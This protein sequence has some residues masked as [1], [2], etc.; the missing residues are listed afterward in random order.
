[1][2]PRTDIIKK[3][4][5]KPSKLLREAKLIAEAVDLNKEEYSK[6]S[7]D[8]LIKRSNFLSNK[9][10]NKEISVEEVVVDAFS[11]FREA[12][13]KVTGL[14]AHNVQLMG[15]YI[16]F[17]GNFA[18]MFTGEGKTLT[19]LFAAYLNALAKKSV[20]VVSVN[21]YLVKRDAEFAE[22]IFKH[23]GITVGYNTSELQPNVKREM[24]SR[25]ITY[26]TNSEL[27]FDYLRD[28][29]VAS[30][31]DK[32][33]KSLDFAIIDEGDSVLI[34]E[35]RT[36]LIISGMPKDD[37]SLYKEVDKFV[38]T[39][40]EEDYII[41]L[42]TNAISLS[43][44]GSEKAEKYF[45]VKNLYSINSSDL[46]HKIGNSLTAN[47]IFKSGREYIVRDDAI[48]LVDAFTGRILEGHSYNAGLQQAIQAKEN[49]KI[50]PENQILATITYQSLFRMYKKLS[51]VSGTAFTE[52]EEFL[53]IYN[54]IVVKVPT[55]KPIQRIDEPDYIFTNKEAK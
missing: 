1:M 35:A 6:L 10:Q 52:A 46:Y 51:A 42:E 33:I 5:N 27:G 50:D 24:F 17:G 18:E 55:N 45:N 16:I 34:D 30:Y 29:M 8:D 4:K 36:P 26:T 23:F 13:Y 2:E 11:I 15:A 54:M 14:F 41:D 47:F 22:S 19:I 48:L 49:V 3:I 39:L 43:P 12:V 40:N 37:V 32:V 25:D 31:D 38:K 7:L 28:N 21:E 9:I 53:K 20:H 44:Y